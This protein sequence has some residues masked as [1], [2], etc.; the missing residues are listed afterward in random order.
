MKNSITIPKQL[1]VRIEGLVTKN[2][3]M[4]LK[5]ALF[6]FLFPQGKGA[7]DGKI[8]LHDY[9]TSPFYIVET[10]FIFYV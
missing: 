1:N 8:S 2:P 5:T 6:P 7:Y 10:L 9:D 4:I 3:F